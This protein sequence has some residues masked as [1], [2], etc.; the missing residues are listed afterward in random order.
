MNVP[1]TVSVV[2]PTFNEQE[3]L[4]DTLQSVAQQTYPAIVE[5]LVADGRS[6]DRTRMVAAEFDRVRVVDNPRRIQAVGLNRAL[7][8]ARGDVI[9]RVDGHCLLAADYVETCVAALETTGAAM[10]GGGMH[11]VPSTRRTSYVQR[12]IAAAMGSRFGAGPA[13][14]HVAGAAA[15]WVD[16]VY[17]G[18]FRADDAR[19]VGGYADD[20]AV[21]E[22][23]EFAL[24]MRE[25]G[26][27][28][29]DPEIRSTYTPRSTFSSL[30]RQFY[31][32]GRGRAATARRHPRHVRPRQLVAP[33]LVLG[34]L[35]PRR[36]QV[37]AAYLALVLARSAY[38]LRKDPESAAALAVALPVMH[39]TWGI[40]FLRGLVDSQAASGSGR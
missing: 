2:I 29:F 24:R 27:I 14:F 32:Y 3:H 18:A 19:A 12:G 36:R 30:A 35:G 7:A 39:L 38:E 23:A 17:L 8:I 15:G 28:W 1:P 13:R 11:P 20:M 5:V 37:A 33:A 6:T 10:V 34:L 26:G 21:N 22:D 16:T 31:R 40:G 9:V 25:N 4:A